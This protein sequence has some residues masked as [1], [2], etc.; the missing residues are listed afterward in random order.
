MKYADLDAIASDGYTDQLKQLGFE[1]V[2]S[3]EFVRKRDSGMHDILGSQ[4]LRSGARLRCWPF[5]WVPEFRSRDQSG[6]FPPN[7]MHTAFP[8]WKFEDWRDTWEVG[9]VDATKRSL[10]LLLQQ[11]RTSVVPW[12]D[13]IQDGQGLIAALD[14]VVAKQAAVIE[15]MP[16]L[17]E[18]YPGRTSR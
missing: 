16:K 1:H 9:S 6:R 14:P 4:I 2:G 15:L 11:I 8:S 18:A 12:F 17:L 5:V 3:F 10:N 7:V 13:S